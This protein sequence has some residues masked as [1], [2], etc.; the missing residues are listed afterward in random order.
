M[1]KNYD[2]NRNP[3][4]RVWILPK[5]NSFQ[6][7][8]KNRHKVR[9]FSVFSRIF[10]I[11]WMYIFR[12][13]NFLRF[14]FASTKKQ[15]EWEKR[16]NLWRH[17]YRQSW[18]HVC[19]YFVC[20]RVCVMKAS[21]KSIKFESICFTFDALLLLLLRVVCD[22]VFVPHH[23]SSLHFIS[24]HVHEAHLLSL[25]LVCSVLILLLSRWYY[26]VHGQFCFALLREYLLANLLEQQTKSDAID[27]SRKPHL[28]SQK[29]VVMLLV[30]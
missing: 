19:R 15:I 24:S 23:F 21:S 14:F 28:T 11:N 27:A 12:G 22:G 3:L 25:P 20:V 4:S 18:A 10:E 2:L 5:S 13:A 1:K 16:G 9:W 8:R 30:V 17:A 6:P 26:C 29:T 7:R